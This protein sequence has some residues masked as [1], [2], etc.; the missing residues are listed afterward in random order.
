M[1]LSVVYMCQNAGHKT[2]GFYVSL[3]QKIAVQH[4]TFPLLTL[5][6]VKCKCEKINSFGSRKYDKSGQQ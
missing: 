6:W 5:N 4:K 2:G 3:S 1:T